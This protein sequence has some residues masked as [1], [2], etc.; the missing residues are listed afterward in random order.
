VLEAGSGAGAGLLCLVHRTGASGLGVELD[1]AL[2]AIAN[3]NAAANGFDALGFVTGDIDGWTSHGRFDHA[4]ANPPYHPLDAPASPDGRRDR[5]KRSS[6]GL[7]AAWT[8]TLARLVREGGTV[9]LVLPAGQ[10]GDALREYAAHRLGSVV[11]FPLWPSEGRAAKLL[12][13]QGRVGGRSSLAL[14][15]GLVLHTAAGFTAQAEAVL[16][17]G[18]PLRLRT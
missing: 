10:L 8:R 12:L 6:P 5:A 16:R 14:S 17:D 4:F 18:A 3:A 9:T 11:V 2:T 13:V 15:A 1:P 7:L